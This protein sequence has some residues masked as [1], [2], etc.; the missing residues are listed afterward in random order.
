MGSPGIFGLPAP[1]TACSPA[2]T[3]VTSERHTP[4]YPASSSG[5]RA[6]ADAALTRECDRIRAGQRAGTITS[7][8][9]VR[10]IEAAHARRDE[11]LR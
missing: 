8:E 5:R 6:A 10:L 2:G 7:A 1:A 9:A 11:A 4:G 3:Q